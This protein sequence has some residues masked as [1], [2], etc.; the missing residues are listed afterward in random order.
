VYWL[1]LLQNLV[2]RFLPSR[3]C[4]TPKALSLPL[5]AQRSRRISRSAARRAI[6]LHSFAEEKRSSRRRRRKVRLLFLVPSSFHP[7]QL[8]FL[9]SSSSVVVISFPGPHGW[10][11]LFTSRAEFKEFVSDLDAQAWAGPEDEAEQ[12]FGKK[13][14]R[15]Q[16]AASW[17]GR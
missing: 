3:R 14:M 15:R 9:V 7:L 16:N 4:T 1:S 13:E 17:F 5:A 11:S 6:K 8:L 10:L 12:K 2:H